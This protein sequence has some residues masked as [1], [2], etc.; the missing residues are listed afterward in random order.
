MGQGISFSSIPADK[1]GSLEVIETGK[2]EVVESLSQAGR[3]GSEFP[4]RFVG[5]AVAGE[6]SKTHRVSAE[7]FQVFGAATKYFYKSHESLRI[8]GFAVVY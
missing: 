6:G 8:S 1:A 4:I 3:V 7:L 5:V 2:F